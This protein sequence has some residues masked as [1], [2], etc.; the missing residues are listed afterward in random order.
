MKH[1]D[2]ETSWE[3]H[4]WVEIKD[5]DGSSLARDEAIQHNRNY[6]KMRETMTKMAEDVTAKVTSAEAA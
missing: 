2:E 1:D 6:S 3:S 5:E 4:G